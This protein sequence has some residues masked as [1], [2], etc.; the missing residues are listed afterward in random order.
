MQVGLIRRGRYVKGKRVGKGNLV[1]D[2]RTP[3]LPPCTS[4]ILAITCSPWSA[5]LAWLLSLE[6]IFRGAG[7]EMIFVAAT[8]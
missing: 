8:G 7:C 4:P 6:V 2:V 3:T 1:S 5:Q